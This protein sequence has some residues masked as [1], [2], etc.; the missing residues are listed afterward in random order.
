MQRAFNAPGKAPYEIL[1]SIP[2][3]AKAIGVLLRAMGIQTSQRI[4][5]IYPFHE[6]LVDGF[7]IE[8]QG[9]IFVDVGAGHGHMV[10]GLRAAIPR[11]PGRLVAQDLP[12]MITTAPEVAGFEWQAYDFFTEQPIKCKTLAFIIEH[13]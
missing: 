11:L 9:V 2:E 13:M 7:D 5:N 8:T 3:D 10:A 4:E 6:R 1:A 12:Y